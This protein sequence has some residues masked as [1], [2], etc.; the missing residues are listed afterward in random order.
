[1]EKGGDGLDTHQ[2]NKSGL[3]SQEQI[4]AVLDRVKDNL[5]FPLSAT[6]VVNVIRDL[7]DAE[8]KRTA[9]AAK[10][11]AQGKGE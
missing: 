7:L 11:T 3:Y 10:A 2:L 8:R 1:M 9:R 6:T 4:A 5:R